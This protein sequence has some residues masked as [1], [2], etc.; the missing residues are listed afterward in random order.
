MSFLKKIPVKYVGELH[1]IR[2]INFLVDL[3]EIKDQVPSSISI[4]DFNGKAMISMVDVRLKKMHPSFFPEFINFSYRHIAFRLLVDDGMY[5]NGLSKG[6]YFYKSFTDKN[7]IVKGGNLFTEYK[8]SNA[9]IEESNDC[10]FIKKANNYVKY[11]VGQT[12]IPSEG[13][14]KDLPQ[15]IGAIDRA[16]SLSGNQLQFTQIQREKWPI[17]L[18]ECTDFENTFFKS[19]ELIGAFR[20]FETIHYQ[21]LPPQIINK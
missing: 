6:I 18:V 14:W 7:L 17:K 21:W 1:D 13:K 19:A 15:V 12:E 2:L 11:K 4:R 9:R 8:L 20:V 5:N 3:E 10:T 16:Y